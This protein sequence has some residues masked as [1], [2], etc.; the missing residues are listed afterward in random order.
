MSEENTKKSLRKDAFVLHA[1]IRVE[2]HLSKL[3]HEHT[4]LLTW[5]EDSL[6]Q[7]MKHISHRLN[8]LLV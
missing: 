2:F 8:R 7:W 5:T 6:S 4:A 3:Q 1:D